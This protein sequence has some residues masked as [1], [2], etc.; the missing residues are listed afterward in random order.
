MTTE[1]SENYNALGRDITDLALGK[2]RD[3]VVLAIQMPIA[4]LAHL[5]RLS[6][7]AGKSLS[8]IVREAV[9][10]YRAEPVAR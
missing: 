3:T 9:A 8:E 10:A 7:A 4:E 2:S 6:A 5:E 1:I